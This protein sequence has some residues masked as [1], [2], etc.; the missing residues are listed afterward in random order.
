M[1]RGTTHIR[2]FPDAL[3]PDGSDLDNRAIRSPFNGGFPAQTTNLGRFSPERLGRELRMASA[4]RGL[5]LCPGFPVG[6]H[7]ATFL[8]HC[9]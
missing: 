6:F 4:V 7:H 1:T 9:R 5:N 2:R 8:R 3:C